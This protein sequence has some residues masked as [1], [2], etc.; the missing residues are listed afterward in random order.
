MD[1]FTI[2]R[3]QLLGSAAVGGL[4]AAF[5]SAMPAASA[6]ALAA[7]S[8]PGKSF[9]LT[10]LGTTD[11]H[12]NILNWDY[13]KDAE[14]DDAQHN[15][16]GLAK[17]ST[18]VAAMRAERGRCATLML[19]AGDTIQGTPLAYYYARIDPITS[20]SAPVHPMA[21]AMNAIGYDAAALGNHEFNY[22]PVAAAPPAA[23]RQRAVLADHQGRLSGVHHQ[24][25]AGG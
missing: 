25:G 19:D 20:P 4:G 14:Y 1:K 11:T 15:D 23:R 3:R 18:L 12:G 5:F 13:Y 17:I 7:A 21:A 22:V 2:S 16:V 10:V 24:E 6:E 9:R 8:Q